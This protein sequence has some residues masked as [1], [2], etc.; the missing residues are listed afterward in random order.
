MS[1]QSALVGFAMLV[2]L[3]VPGS[4]FAQFPPPAGS[5]GAGNSAISGIP[6]GP[7][8]PSVVSDPSGIGNASRIPPPGTNSPAPS[9][10]YSSVN[11]SPSGSRVVVPPYAGASQRITVPRQAR[12]KRPP[13]RPRGRVETSK[14]TGI[15][16]GC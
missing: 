7:A 10:S 12:S 6:Y 8:N 1:G 4:A 3:I 13:V 5:A 15:C 9:P 14:F 11:A 16:R 2:S